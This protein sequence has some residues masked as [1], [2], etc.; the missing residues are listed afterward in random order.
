MKKYLARFTFRCGESEV[1]FLHGVE[2]SDPSEA[3]RKISDY[4]ANFACGAEKED[5]WWVY[6]GGEF[7]VRL[8]EL[9]ELPDRPE[10][11][12]EALWRELLPIR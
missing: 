5:G 6:E 3:E 8:S 9:L 10:E 7:A 2:A 11:Q 12:L 4:L 1:S